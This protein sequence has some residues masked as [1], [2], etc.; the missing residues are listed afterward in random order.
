M[1]AEERLEDQPVEARG[2]RW[3]PSPLLDLPPL[4]PVFALRTPHRMYL[5]AMPSSREALRLLLQCRPFEVCVE[6]DDAAAPLQHVPIQDVHEVCLAPDVPLPWEHYYWLAD[7]LQN[8]L[9]SQVDPGAGLFM[10]RRRLV[11]A[12]ETLGG[13]RREPIHELTLLRAAWQAERSQESRWNGARDGEGAAAIYARKLMQH[14]VEKTGSRAFADWMADLRRQGE[15][16][17]MHSLPIL[18]QVER[19]LLATYLQHR[20]LGNVA[21]SSPA[22]MVTGWQLLVATAIVAVCFAGILVRAGYESDL[23]EA[24]VASLWMLDQ[25]FWCDETLVH[26]TLRHLSQQKPSASDLTLSLAA[27]LA[28]TPSR[29]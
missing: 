6:M 15:R 2:T 16:L 3:I 26:E 9:Q 1:D 20:S 8:D 10:G 11:V 18:T 14:L 21:L 19:Q 27:A 24:L 22:G 29:A 5:Q 17:Q 28:R 4:E 13:V 25:G 7:G 12:A 23:D